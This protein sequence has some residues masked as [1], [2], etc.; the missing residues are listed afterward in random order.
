MPGVRPA[1][2][3]TLRKLACAP[4]SVRLLILNQLFIPPQRNS[5]LENT[6][7]KRKLQGSSPIQWLKILTRKRYL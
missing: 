2:D 6:I 5:L 7:F 3:R 1:K 4:L